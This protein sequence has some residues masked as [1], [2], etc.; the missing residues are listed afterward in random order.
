MTAG[1][2]RVLTHSAAPAYPNDFIM[3]DM[4]T[5]QRIA[6]PE[7]TVFGGHLQLPLVGSVVKI[8]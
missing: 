6:F 8:G 7:S 5:V 4:T 2:M 3:L 1:P